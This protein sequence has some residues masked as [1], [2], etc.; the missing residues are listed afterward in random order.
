VGAW[1]GVFVVLTGWVA[2][3]VSQPLDR[4]VFVWARPD[5]EWALG[6]VRWASVVEALRPPVAATAVSF[7]AAV[8]CVAHRSLRP[9]L[10]TAGTMAMAAAGTLLVKVALARPDPHGTGTGHGGSFP[11]GHTVGVVLAVG[12]TVHLLAPGARRWRSLGAAAA[13]GLMG[14]A[15][16]VIGAHWV[17]DVAGGLVLGF[18]VLAAVAAINDRARKDR[19]ATG[20]ALS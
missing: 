7:V 9:A 12:L 19:R 11:S 18:A 14:T 10:V 8:V 5:D 1:W 4:W 2:L 6:Q 13:G 17:T 3:G 20:E 16:V 15:L